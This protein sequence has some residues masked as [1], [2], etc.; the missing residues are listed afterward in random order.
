VLVG[1]SFGGYNA[2]V[3]GGRYSKDVAA[4][5][6][7]DATHEDQYALLPLRWNAL[8]AAMLERYQHQA[9]WAPVNVEFG[10]TRL[11]LWIRGTEVSHLILQTKYLR[12]RASELE[13]IRVSAEQARAAGTLGD[14]PL[15]VL[16]A[17]KSLDPAA[18]GGLSQKEVAE[19]QEVWVDDLQLRLAGLSERGKRIVIPDSGHDM[20]SERPDAIAEAVREV[21]SARGTR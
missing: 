15:I 19:Y 12:A 2:R 1:H 20:P 6:L 3:F 5:V 16:T 8:G 17:G 7:V 4:M 10:I 13:A 21:L 9:R 18:S 14:K 11:Q